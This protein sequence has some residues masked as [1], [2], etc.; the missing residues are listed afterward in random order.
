M[1]QLQQLVKAAM[2]RLVASTRSGLSGK[3]ASTRCFCWCCEHYSIPN[4]AKGKKQ[5][6]RATL[7]ME[8]AAFAASDQGDQAS[9][10]LS[11]KIITD[12]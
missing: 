3:P 10:P 5:K 2:E 6:H 8:R 4:C 7:E 9:L 11:D 12:A 1:L